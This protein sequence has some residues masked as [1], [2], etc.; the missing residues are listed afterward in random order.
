MLLHGPL[1]QIGVQESDFGLAPSR[2]LQGSN[3]TCDTSLVTK[4]HITQIRPPLFRLAIFCVADGD[5]LVAG[6]E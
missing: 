1:Q 3:T 2:V 5:S 4:I 6:P